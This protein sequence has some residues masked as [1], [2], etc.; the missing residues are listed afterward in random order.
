MNESY[1]SKRIINSSVKSEEDLIALQDKINKEALE[2]AKLSLMDEVHSDSEKPI[3][4]LL[5]KSNVPVKREF[6]VT[7]FCDFN[8]ENIDHEAFGLPLTECI[9]DECQAKVILNVPKK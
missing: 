3:H 5:T 4:I 2:S 7:E 9:E 6:Y 1:K 8:C